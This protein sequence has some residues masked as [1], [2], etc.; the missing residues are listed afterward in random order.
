M[1]M[2]GDTERIK[3]FIGEDAIPKDKVKDVL[4]N[5]NKYYI[6]EKGDGTS[7]GASEATSTC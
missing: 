3:S 6:A 7:G 5:Y 4:E 1:A 2:D